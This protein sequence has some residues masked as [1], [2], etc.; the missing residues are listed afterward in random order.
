MTKFK[1]SSGYLAYRA[2]AAETT[3]LGGR[4]IC[5]DCGEYAPEGYLVPVLNHYMCEECF[6]VFEGCGAFYPEDIPHEQ[7]TAAYFENRIPL[8][9][10]ET[11]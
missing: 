6:K 11:Q 8:E 10:D 7:H 3:L 9:G 2:T 4:G 5:D 1:T